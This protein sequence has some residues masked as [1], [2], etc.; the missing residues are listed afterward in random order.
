MYFPGGQI[1]RSKRFVS[2]EI[3]VYFIDC[4]VC[5]Q[6]KGKIEKIIEK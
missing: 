2:F 4:N 3:L 6:N 1:V 5:V